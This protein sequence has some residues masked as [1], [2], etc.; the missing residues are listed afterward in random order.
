MEVIKLVI[1][2]IGGYFSSELNLSEI[3]EIKLK[4]SLEII[5]T[6]LS[7]FIILLLFFSLIGKSM[8]FI[9]TFPFLSLL[10][11]LTGGLHFKTYFGC[12]SFSFAFFLATLF[13]STYVYL[14]D[15]HIILILLFSL[16]S[17]YAAAPVP[18]KGRPKY[19]SKKIIKFKTLAMLLVMFSALLFYLTH[20]SPLLVSHIWVMLFESVQLLIS[21][22][23]MKY[24]KTFQKT[25]RIT[26]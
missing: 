5:L 23:V 3:D 8:F 2:K 12:L 14:D 21:K 13:C 17:I 18:A 19:S 26:W 16:I 25:D 10:R 9:L 20:K 1:N 7:K 4:Y 15:I 6:D 11:I 24:E 22:E